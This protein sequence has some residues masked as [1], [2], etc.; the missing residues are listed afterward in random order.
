MSSESS[1]IEPA[2]PPPPHES[3]D[4]ELMAAFKEFQ[5]VRIVGRWAGRA[6]NQK[7]RNLRPRFESSESSDFEPVPPT[8]H[9]SE[10]S[11]LR[12]TQTRS[13]GRA[14]LFRFKGK[15]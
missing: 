14:L 10:D 2:P 3:E 9:E 11:E 6:Q 12:K 1:D 15:L 4:S 5:V 7:T 8:A 13:I